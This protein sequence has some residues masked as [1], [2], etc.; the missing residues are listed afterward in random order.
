LIPPQPS[1]Y[2]AHPKVSENRHRLPLTDGIL[3]R[4]LPMSIDE[5]NLDNLGNIC[6]ELSSNTKG[7]LVF[8]SPCLL[9][10]GS[11]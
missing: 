4:L 2:K 1:N 10:E 7:L 11:A 6:L 3:S 9:I 8:Y 5:F